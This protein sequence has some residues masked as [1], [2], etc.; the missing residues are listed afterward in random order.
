[1]QSLT[2][3][4]SRLAVPRPALHAAAKEYKATRLN[5]AR[6]AGQYYAIEIKTDAKLKEL[7]MLKTATK[8]RKLAQTAHLLLVAV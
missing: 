8:P 2:E 6:L 7:T 4:A 1:M 3:A 5:I